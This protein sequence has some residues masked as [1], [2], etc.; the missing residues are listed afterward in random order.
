MICFACVL[1]ARSQ[2][3]VSLLPNNVAYLGLERHEA[4]SSTLLYFIELT[5]LRYKATVW[6]GNTNKPCL[7][8]GTYCD[9]AIGTLHKGIGLSSVMVTLNEPSYPEGG[10]AHCP[11]AR[12]GYEI[13]RHRPWNNYI[14]RCQ[15]M[16]LWNS[17]T[18]NNWEI[19]ADRILILNLLD[20][21]TRVS[22]WQQ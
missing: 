13:K 8:D 22:I 7:Q 9:H 11:M 4:R 1:Q 10:S 18:I 16:D 3:S 2:D 17:I 6:R 15:S 12:Y 21:K 19:L 20:I 5:K 14:E